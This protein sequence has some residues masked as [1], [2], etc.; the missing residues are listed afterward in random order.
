MPGVWMKKTRA[1]RVQRLKA[2]RKSGAQLR[3]KQRAARLAKIHATA[4]HG[5][6]AQVS[7]EPQAHDQVLQVADSPGKDMA[8]FSE[9]QEPQPEPLTATAL[10]KHTATDEQ[11]NQPL[12]S[13]A[14]SNDVSVSSDEFRRPDAEVPLVEPEIAEAFRRRP[15]VQVR[16]SRAASPRQRLTAEALAALPG[17]S[18]S[19]QSDDLGSEADTAHSV[20]S[21][22]AWHQ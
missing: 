10:A 16:E 1:G 13:R 5:V 8:S 20:V 11:I 6:D 4:E 9:A 14:D 15:Q 18:L 7:A 12:G 21:S 2:A 19:Q 22:T 17:A 3:A